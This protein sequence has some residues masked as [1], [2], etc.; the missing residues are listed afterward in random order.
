MKWQQ[1]ACR[2]AS[3]LVKEVLLDR[4]LFHPHGAGDKKQKMVKNMKNEKTNE[5]RDNV[6][7]I[8]IGAMI[9]FIA[10]ILV[11]AVAAAVIIQTAEK[12]QQNAQT[13]GQD[14]TDKMA[15][16]LSVLGVIVASGSSL[17]VTFE[18]APGSDDVT[19]GDI[20]WAIICDGG[21]NQ[22][23]FPT[24]A[25][26]HEVGDTTAAGTIEAG[27]TYMT[28]LS[29]LA[30]AATCAPS[31]N[32]EHTILFQAGGG[33]QTYEVLNYGGDVTAGAVVI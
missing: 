27:K 26:T 6:A 29:G 12:L 5:N 7:A 32:A 24:T 10:L 33:G 23:A 25:T 14:T 8:G 15:A 21:K 16:R 4:V 31:P 17:D 18:L 19:T 30:A 9:V 3:T 22:G 13:T 2:F 1:Y 11:A 28:T 20:G